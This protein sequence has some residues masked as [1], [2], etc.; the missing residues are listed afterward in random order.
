MGRVVLSYFH[1]EM[2]SVFVAIV[3]FFININILFIYVNVGQNG[4]GWMG[5]LN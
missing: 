4:Y 1:N 2:C 5:F 3:S